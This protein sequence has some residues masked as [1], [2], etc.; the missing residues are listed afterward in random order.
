ME[1]SV[2]IVSEQHGT[3]SMRDDDLGISTSD[4]TYDKPKELN[5]DDD[6]ERGVRE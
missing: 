3:P 4:D 1:V 6:V 2:H 5:R